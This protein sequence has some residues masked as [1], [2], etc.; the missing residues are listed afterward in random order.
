VAPQTVS[1]ATRRFV[2]TQTVGGVETNAWTGALLSSGFTT[3][4]TA[5]T[6]ALAQ[7]DAL[8]AAN[9]AILY[10]VYSPS[11]SGAH[12]DGDCVW[13]SDIEYG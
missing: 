6:A 4:R 3:D 1:N 9:P 10:R 7:A 11:N 8:K 2:I 5:R 13:R 12:S